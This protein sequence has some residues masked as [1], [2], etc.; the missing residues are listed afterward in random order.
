MGRKG[1]ETQKEKKE[2][3]EENEGKRTQNRLAPW[4]RDKSIIP[5]SP[6]T[7]RRIYFQ[8]RNKKV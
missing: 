3:G 4:K 8:D 6:G 5:Q 1:R 7:P 2:K